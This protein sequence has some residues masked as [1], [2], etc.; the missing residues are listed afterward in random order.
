MSLT[1][2]LILAL[3]VWMLYMHMRPGG[4]GGCGTHGHRDSAED[5]RGD[6]AGGSGR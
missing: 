5:D 3:F 2:I 1:T 4:H 6:P